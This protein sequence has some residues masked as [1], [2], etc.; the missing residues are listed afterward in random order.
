M[1]PIIGI[2]FGYN[3]ND[4]TNNYIRAIE[5]HG[6]I[7]RTLYPGAP[8][9]AFSGLNGLLLTGGRD[10]DPIHYGEKEHET[11]DIDF[12]RDELELPLCKRAMEEDLP[13]FGICR[14]IQIMNVAI[15]SSLYQ[16]IP[17]QLTDHLTHKIMKNTDDSWHNIRIQPDSLLNRITGETIAEVN[18]RHHQA[19]KVIGEGFNVTAQSKDGIIEAIE[20]T[21]K[22]F[23][24]G[25]QY[26][27]E[28]MFKEPD[29]LELQEHSTK[30]FTAFIDAC[31]KKS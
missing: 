27:P 8:L 17:S 2:T 1:K 5:G 21:S 30:L 19:L 25:V 24:L 11:T 14:G 22:R 6:G 15:G 18:S 7:V 23:I 20:D 29:S 10:I 28:R 9:E 12:D 3:E 4:P 31:S 26:H 13:V 16:D